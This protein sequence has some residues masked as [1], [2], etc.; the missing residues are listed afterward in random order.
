MIIGRKAE[1]QALLKAY[2]SEYSEFVAVTGRRRVGKTFLVRETFDYKFAFQHS[3]L[4][5][6]NT[7]AQLRE[8]RQ[9]LVRFGMEKCRVPVDWSDAFFLLSQLLDRQKEGKK[10]VFIDELPW[11][12]APRSNF[13]SA[14]EHFWN[15]YAS[16]RKDILLIICGSATSWIINNVFKDHGGLHNRVTYKINLAPFSLNECEQYAKSRRLCMSRYGILECYMIMGGIPFYWSM[17]ERG[18]SVAQNIDALFFSPMGKLHYEYGE[19]YQSLFKNPEPY[20]KVVETLGT[21]RMGMT[22]DEL[23]HEGSLSNNGTL[24]GILEDLEACGFI[25]KYSYQGIKHIT[26]IYQLIDN[27][28]LFYYKFLHNRAGVEENFWSINT[29]TPIRNAWEGLAFERVCFEHIQQ[30]KQ[31]LGIAGVAIQVYSWRVKDDPVYGDGAQ[32]DMII[33]R[34]DHIVNLCE[35]KFSTTVYAIEKSVDENLR[36]KANRFSETQKGHKAVHTILIT[37]FGIKQN[38]YQ[39]SVQNVVTAEDLFKQE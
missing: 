17:L 25:R 20:I 5:N 4:A 12:D 26:S 9:S 34:A 27:Y 18:K 6:Q 7:R 38:R 29:N 24:T 30:I 8:F 2:T 31:A 3:G 22:R 33:D 36:H 10:V 32:I 21:K 15:G 28:T 19:L 11:M 23:I 37:P 16:A 14:I 13:V 35:M 39:Y 1:Q